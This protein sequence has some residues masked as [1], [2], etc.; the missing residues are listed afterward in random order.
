[1]M[2]HGRAET[3]ILLLDVD[4]VEKKM[5]MSKVLPKRAMVEQ[6]H[7]VETLQATRDR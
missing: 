3:P 2:A 1:M 6:L 4:G 5:T 7:I